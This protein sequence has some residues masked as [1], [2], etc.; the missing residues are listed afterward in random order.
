MEF[1]C[2]LA[3]GGQRIH[4]DA[5]LST[6]AW[7]TFDTEQV[8]QIQAYEVGPVHV[9]GHTPQLVKVP[10]GVVAMWLPAQH[11]LFAT[12]AAQ[13]GPGTYTEVVVPGVPRRAAIRLARSVTIATLKALPPRLATP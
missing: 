1:R 4:V 13:D 10:H 6:Q 7:A 12:N 9:R 8:H 5:Q 11:K 3:G 2:R